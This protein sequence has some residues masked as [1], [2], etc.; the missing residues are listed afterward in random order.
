MKKENIRKIILKRKKIIAIGSVLLILVGG[1]IF[2]KNRKLKKLHVDNWKYNEERFILKKGEINNSIIASGIIKSGEVSNV[3][4]SIN[5]KVKSIN[6]SVGDVVKAGDI[7]CTLDNSDIN[8]E[9]ENKTKAIEEE[10]KSL[11]DN[12]NKLLNKLNS[13]KSAQTGNLNNDEAISTALNKLNN[14][15]AEL[16]SYESKFNSIKNTY[17]VML[18]GI[19]DKQDNYN[20]AESNKNKYYEEWIKSGGNTDSQ[21]YIKYIDANENLQRLEQELNQAK[22]LYDYDNISSKYSEALSIYNDKFAAVDVARSEYNEALSNSK[23]VSNINKEEIE[24]LENNI[25]DVH[26]Q[27]QKLNDNEEL[28]ELKENLN[29]TVLKAETSG[30]ITDLKVNVGSVA[31]GIIATIQSTDNLILEVNIPEY[32]IKKVTTGMNVKISSNTLADKVNGKL[33]NISPVASSGEKS[34][35]SAN[36]SI[37]NGSGLYI[38]TSAKAEIMISSKSDVI[39][40]PIDAIKDIDNNPSVLLAD[41]NGEFKEIPVNLGEKNDYYIEIS[42]DGIK[43]GIEIKS[44]IESDEN[45]NNF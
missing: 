3:S 23:S 22:V 24:S 32:D 39:I 9:I 16:S 2:V 34:G 30:K 35:F 37:E 43:E 21:E 13:L 25:N 31:E 44:N 20:N 17:N 1:F 33:T 45:N 41:E 29:K 26:K 18:S 42:G 5:A 28:K 8:K 19:K 15:N 6:V 4:S 38:G 27:I 12:Y 11:Q 10:R 7:I 40:A 14:A 36:I